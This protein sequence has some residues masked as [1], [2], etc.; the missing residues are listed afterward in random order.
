M[1]VVTTCFLKQPRRLGSNWV[2]IYLDTVQP[3]PGRYQ[4]KDIGAKERHQIE[5]KYQQCRY[6]QCYESFTIFIHIPKMLSRKYCQLG[7]LLDVPK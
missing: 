5:Q 2:V 3:R 1:P 4:P 6:E 7:L